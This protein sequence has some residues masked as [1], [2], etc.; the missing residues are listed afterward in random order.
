M[1][2]KK[3]YIYYNKVFDDSFCKKVIDLGLSKLQDG[4]TSDKKTKT[5]KK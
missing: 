1:I 4:Q 2:L 5:K 3:P